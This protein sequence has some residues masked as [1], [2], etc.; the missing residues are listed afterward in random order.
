MYFM[1]QII[2]NYHKTEIG[3]FIIG[4]Y[5]NKI[6]IFDYRYRTQREQ[7]NL[8]VCKL[9]KAEFIEKEHELI[10]QAKTQLNEYLHNKRKEFN[11][12]LLLVGLEFEKKVWEE[13]LHI[14]YGKTIS[15][16]ELAKK[17]GNEKAFR[18]V[19]NANGRNSIAIIVPCHR[20]IS[21]NGSLGGY[22][23]GISV[24]QK[25]LNLEKNKS[26]I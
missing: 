7:L 4:I 11:L 9:L 26:L 24:K 13:L 16:L 6:C 22:S 8:K 5:E 17:I 18:A 3:E 14:K 15:Y 12:P 19:A 10:E 20:V 1:N 21:S 23:G 25:L 2:I